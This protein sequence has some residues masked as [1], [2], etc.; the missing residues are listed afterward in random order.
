MITLGGK[1]SGTW[2]NSQGSLVTL[3]TVLKVNQTSIA[4][5]FGLPANTVITRVFALRYFKFTPGCYEVL[6]SWKLNLEK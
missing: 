5:E 2:T 4:R 6:L 3:A 1:K